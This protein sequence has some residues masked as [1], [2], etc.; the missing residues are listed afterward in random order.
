MKR[1][2]GVAPVRA[3]LDRGVSRHRLRQALER[4]QIM[5][6]RRGWVA[7][8]N[9][10]PQLLLAASTGTVLSCITQAKRLGLWVLREPTPHLAAPHPHAEII[11]RRGK[12]HW[13]QPLLAR[14]PVSLVDP[15]QNVL[16]LVAVC[17]PFEEALAIWESALNAKLVD[18]PSL[19]LL[20]YRG[21]ARRV[22]QSC[23]PYS[24]S[25]L[26][27][28]V[29]QRLAWLRVSVVQQ[30]WMHGR[31]VDLL[32]DGWLVLQI[33]GG[34]HVGAQ[35]DADMLHDAELMLQ[36]LEVI[37]CSYDQVVHRWPQVQSL[38]QRALARGPHT[39]VFSASSASPASVAR[40]PEKSRI[41]EQ[42]RAFHPG[43]GISPGNGR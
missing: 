34:H 35:R 16:G 17:Q 41:Q 39:P 6:V 5:A 15:I 29:R 30:S 25:G 19:T 43:D 8:P 7:L 23:Q 18:L 22:L 3:L 13:A 37:R 21:R 42:F 10:D 28:F 38:I 14:D 1:F 32:I 26:E 36:G 11:H 20:P 40:L 31:R 9:A 27:T 12:I 2:G 33:D 4:C 24:D